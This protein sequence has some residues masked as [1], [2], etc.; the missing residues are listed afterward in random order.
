MNNDIPKLEAKEIEINGYKFTISKMPSTIAQ[1]VLMQIPTGLIPIISNF[2][3]AENAVFE[4]LSYCDRVYP[5]GRVVKLI[6]RAIIDNNVPDL[7][8]L[9][10]LEKEVWEYNYDFL[11]FGAL[12]PFL[13]KCLCRVESNLS[14]TLMDLLDK[15]LS[16]AGQR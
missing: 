14:K 7:Q 4:M 11:D 8:T 9:M 1:R 2:T 13:K 12:A 3:N 10:Q 6:N 16:V 15:L 5:D